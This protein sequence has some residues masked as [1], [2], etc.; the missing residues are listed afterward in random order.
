MPPIGWVSGAESHPD[1]FD[2]SKGAPV[3]LRSGNAFSM[4]GW[5]IILDVDYPKPKAGKMFANCEDPPRDLSFAK[6]KF[7]KSRVTPQEFCYGC[8]KSIGR[9]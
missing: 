2:E 7:L 8:A 5:W 6:E 1:E 3:R 9:C 4:I